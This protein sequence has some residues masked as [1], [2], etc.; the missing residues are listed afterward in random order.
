MITARE[1]RPRADPGLLNALA[2]FEALAQ[3]IAGLS[4]HYDAANWVMNAAEYRWW[5]WDPVRVR[6]QIFGQR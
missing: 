1:D 4:G 6:T 5:D 3:E 2:T